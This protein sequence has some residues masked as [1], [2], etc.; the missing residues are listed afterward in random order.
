MK[1]LIDALVLVMSRK[2]SRGVAVA[3]TCLFILLLLAVQN[4]KSALQIFDLTS[5]S[6]VKQVRFFVV[7][8]FDI[9]S[10]FTFGTIFLAILGSGIGGINLA[11][12]YTYMKIRG[13]IIMKS[14]LYS[15]VGL[16]LAFIGVGCAACG[17]VLLS[18]IL[19]LFGFAAIL[20]KLPYQGQEVGYLGLLLISIATY[21][22][23]K[24]VMAPAVC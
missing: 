21:T 2:D 22:L 12:L 17:S 14:G 24:K 18:I 16:F 20:E 8:F 19:G 13:G 5:L 4:G 10:T 11:L 23:A 7:T 9:H 6:F 3:S 1:V 15:G